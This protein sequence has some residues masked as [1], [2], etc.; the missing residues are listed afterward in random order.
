[1]YKWL[2]YCMHFILFHSWL[3]LHVKY[4]LYSDTGL[5]GMWS[6]KLVS[7]L[8]S[9]QYGFNMP[10]ICTAFNCCIYSS[11]HA[12]CQ[13]TTGNV[14]TTC[15]KTEEIIMTLDIVYLHSVFKNVSFVGVWLGVVWDDCGRSEQRLRY[16]GSSK[17]SVGIWWLFCL[18]IPYD[19]LIGRP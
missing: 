14:H 6:F 15:S 18:L 11:V 12:L 13:M 3:C 16:M 5:Q 4:P 9:F 8:F 7:T 1:M 19:Y 17:S 2:A 10:I